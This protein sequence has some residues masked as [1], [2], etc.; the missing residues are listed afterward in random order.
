MGPSGFKLV[1]DAQYKRHHHDRKPKPESP[2]IDNASPYKPVPR[3]LSEERLL[4]LSKPQN[5]VRSRPISTT[6]LLLC[7]LWGH[8]RSMRN[9]ISRLPANK[10]VFRNLGSVHMIHGRDVGRAVRSV[11][12]DFAKA[13]GRR[14]ILTNLRV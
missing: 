5:A 9:F 3:A 14:W 10:E 11:H 7:G 12:Q 4:A 13:N 1:L 8:G 2:W 6:V